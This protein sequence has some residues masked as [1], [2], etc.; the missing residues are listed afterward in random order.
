VSSSKKDTETGQKSSRIKKR[1]WSRTEE[2]TNQKKILKQ[3]RRAHESKKDTEKTTDKL[4]KKNRNER[5]DVLCEVRSYT[6]TVSYRR[7]TWFMYQENCILFRDQSMQFDCS[8][9]TSA[10][11]KEI[12][13]LG[14]KKRKCYDFCSQ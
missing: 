3:D 8:N 6:V 10:E 11:W 14:Q 4:S 5:Y 9:R 12:I 13:F 2:L 7:S 1:Y